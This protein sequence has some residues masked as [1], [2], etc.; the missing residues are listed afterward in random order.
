MVADFNKKRNRDFF[1]EDFWFRT[2]GII[3]LI[4][5]VILI[6]KDFKIYQRKQELKSQINALQ[7]QVEDIK[8]SSQNLKNDIANTD[9]IDYLEK[10]GYEQFNVTKPGE[11]E[12]IFVTPQEKSKNNSNSGNFWYIFTNWFSQS[13]NWIKKL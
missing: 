8:K 2:I 7:K 11:K 1:N 13:W 3:V 12:I 5:I 4:I 9:N 6:F 10:L